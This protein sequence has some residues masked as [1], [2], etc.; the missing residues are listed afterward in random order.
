[1]DKTGKLVVISGPSGAGKST[2]AREV[3]HRTDAQFSV[4]VTTRSP[5]PSEQDGREYRFVDRPTFRGMI[6]RGEMLEWAEV[7][8]ELYGTPIGPVRDALAGGR[9]VLLDIDIQG[10]EQ[11]HRAMPDAT[12]V[13]IV[14]PCEAELQRRLEQRGSETP[15]SLAKRLTKAD[16]E[17]AA[18]TAGGVYNQV[19]VNDDL[20][21]A[22]TQIV[23]IVNR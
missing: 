15:E 4:S 3:L 12:F 18:A 8:D 21:D 9:T 16:E 22:V 11:V 2:L 14:P 6:D 19:I 20:E 1:M 23:E 17:I 10:G 5:R 13:L 7:F